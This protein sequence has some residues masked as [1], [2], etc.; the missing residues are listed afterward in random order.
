MKKQYSVVR[1]DG[2]EASYDKLEY[3]RKKGQV[4]EQFIESEGRNFSVQYYRSKILFHP[5][6][7]AERVRVREID[8]MARSVCFRY[9]KK[10]SWARRVKLCI[11]YLYYYISKTKHT[12]GLSKDVWEP[13]MI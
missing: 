12:L 3:F 9:Y 1:L 10:W 11:P 2:I 8:H 6:N 13:E 4:Y 7:K 5:G